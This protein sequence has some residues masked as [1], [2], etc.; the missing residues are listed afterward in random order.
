ML[1][2]VFHAY[3]RQKLSNLR[4]TKTNMIT[5]P[6]YTYHRIHFTSGNISFCD[7]CL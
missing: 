7:N 5:C 4:Q 3:L 1:K 2:I 6:F